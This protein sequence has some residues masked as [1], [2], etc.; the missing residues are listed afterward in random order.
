MIKD[1]NIDNIDNICNNFLYQFAYFLKKQK[2]KFQLFHPCFFF[3]WICMGQ[4]VSGQM[5][6]NN[7]WK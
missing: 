3:E 6:D 4:I 7:D 2:K 1:K 5:V